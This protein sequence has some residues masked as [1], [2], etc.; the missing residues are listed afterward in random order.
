[1]TRAFRRSLTVAVLYPVIAFCSVSR[2]SVSAME[3]MIDRRLTGL[4]PDEPVMVGLT[5][6]VYITS[7]GT[8]FMATVN[9]SPAAGITP[10]HQTISKDEVVRVHQKKADRLPKLKQLMQDLLVSSAAS[11]D[12][13]PPDEQIALAISLFYFHWEDVHGLPAQ[14]VMHGPKKSLIAVQSGR[15]SRDTLAQIISVE[16]Y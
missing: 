11:L 3:Q 7:Y 2:T 5:N 12:G 1:M 4:A 8:V 15:A 6:G 10:F 16:E 14:I 9:L 13:V